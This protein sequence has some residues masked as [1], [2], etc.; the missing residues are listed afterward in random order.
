MNC[1]QAITTVA[2]KK[3][4]Q[5][6]RQRLTNLS[7][8]NRS[9]ILTRLY[10][11][12][13]IDLQQYDFVLGKP[14]F[15][16]V[17]QLLAHKS[18]IPLCQTTDARD[19]ANNR[20]S[21]LTRQLYRTTQ[22][23]LEEQGA[24]NLCVGYP[25][26]QGKLNNDTFIRCPLLFFPVRLAMRNDKWGLVLREDVPVSFNKTFL[27]AYAHHNG[28]ALNQLLNEWTLE[29]PAEDVTVFL[30]A[31]YRLLESASLEVHFN[32]EQFGEQ[33]QPFTSFTRKELDA[34]TA[35]GKLKLVPE[36]VLGQFPQADSYLAPDYDVLL[37]DEQ[38]ADLEMFFNKA[39]VRHAPRE[40]EIVTPYEID[41]TQEKA[42]RLIK[43]GQSLVVQ[44]PPGTGK[45]Q[46][47]VNLIA[48][49]IASGKRVLVVCQKKAALD[50]VYNRLQEKELH[51]FAALVHDFQQDRARIYANIARQIQQVQERHEQRV[52][53]E[54]LQNEQ[55]F[56][57]LA[58]QITLQE[59]ELEDFRKALFDESVCGISAKNLY[60]TSSLQQKHIALPDAIR[61]YFH[62]EKAQAFLLT[63]QRYI[64]Y[65]K[66]TDAAVSL[67]RNRLSFANHSI[68]EQQQIRQLLPLVPGQIAAIKQSLAENPLA[69]SFV[70]NKWATV[71]RLCEVANELRQGLMPQAD[72]TRWEAFNR[73]A[74]QWIGESKAKLF[75]EWHSHATHAVAA[76]AALAPQQL[77]ENS[78]P[79][80][81]AL[82]QTYLQD[83][84][85][86]TGKIKWLFSGKKKQIGAWL[87]L[88]GLPFTPEGITTMLHQLNCYEQWQRSKASMQSLLPFLPYPESFR[89]DEWAAFLAQATAYRRFLQSWKK[90]AE[91]WL[92][93]FDVKN[94]D[95]QQLPLQWERLASVLTQIR[96]LQTAWQ[97]F[98]APAQQEWLWAYP[99]E[100][101]DMLRQAEELFEDL[102]ALDALKEQLSAEER[103]TIDLLI[104]E[105]PEQWDSW[106][107]VF[108]NSWRL[109]WLMA[110][111]NRFPVLR[112]ASGQSLLQTAAELRQNVVQ[113]QQ[114]SLQI[115]QSRAWERAFSNLE[116]NRLQN[117]VSYRDLLHQVSKKRG[118]WPLR[119]LIAT[120]W[121]E[122][123]NL[124]PCW[125][126][127]PESASALFPMQELFDMV[128]FDE[129]SQCFAEKGIPAMYRGRQAV[130]VGDDKQLAPFDLY[131]PRWEEVNPEEEIAT[132]L[133]VESLLDLGKRYLP[134]MMLTGHY[135]SRYPELIGFSNR[136]FYQEK[137]QMLPYKTDWQPQQ[138]AIRFVKVEGIWE[139]KTNRT[140]AEIVVQ[141]IR[142]Q[143]ALQPD[144]SIGVI[145][146]NVHQQQLI[147]DLLEQSDIVLPESLFVKNIENVQGDERDCIIFSVGYAPTVSGRMQLNF[148]S[149]S[150][151]KGENR[152]NVAITRAREQIVVI[153]SIYP[154]QLQVENTANEGARLLR[155]YLEYAFAVSQ[156]GFHT[157]QLWNAATRPAS[158][159]TLAQ[160][161]Q[162]ADERL[163]PGHP[164]ADLIAIDTGKHPTEMIMTDDLT[165]YRAVSAR[166]VFVYQPLHFT[167]KLWQYRY[168]FSRNWWKNN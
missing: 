138:S 6:F 153:S 5:V 57:Q 63:L 90:F 62:A 151:A 126:V 80:A 123:A 109:A 143:L 160:R 1:F 104:A 120:H 16:I 29:N 118:V 20:V 60:L 156:Q 11:G 2:V 3:L 150:Q 66:H 76:A 114:L 28:Q 86:W 31:L 65:A 161:L 26:V 70:Q 112:K 105:A 49:A 83:H 162:A 103:Q 145:T 27:L 82:L 56:L 78:I 130:I 125:L 22:S 69:A 7:G 10:I 146:F 12:Q 119:K 55:Q 51:H 106:V 136:Y 116:Y 52:D 37:T 100:A 142:K 61:D 128:I 85:S 158:A 93:D 74:A 64:A 117:L 154:Q 97:P 48:D 131:R 133:E 33:L 166:S 167:R 92:P 139:D 149:L 137:L 36:A 121:E 9:L 35:T 111:E 44:G 34:V 141:T 124:V 87:A 47:I 159:P 94:T 91:Q 155:A 13:H 14:A 81:K 15:D 129:A 38:V 41:A 163:R 79:Q 24:E 110:L 165:L 54:T 19:A 98:L 77:E 152:L 140:E 8:N 148:G 147:M 32:A 4:L 96:T 144:K 71:N 67:W 17:R 132:E 50:V 59:R 53:V 168:V 102:C 122:L 107:A 73:I 135:R 43:S 72:C 58:R 113:K 127:S 89:G 75:D 101:A 84:Q 157:N 39:T 21:Y 108:N 95:W 115:A 45:S 30:T 18:W 134:Q 23:V 99:E 164:F 88:Y 46:L 25:F 40:E 42:L 68:R